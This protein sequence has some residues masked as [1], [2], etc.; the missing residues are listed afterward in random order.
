MSEL[1]IYDNRAHLDEDAFRELVMYVDEYGSEVDRTLEEALEEHNLAIQDTVNAIRNRTAN[2]EGREG[3]VY[4]DFSTFSDYLDEYEDYGE[5]L[6]VYGLPSFDGRG[7]QA[8][9]TEFVSIYS[10]TGYKEACIGFV[11]LLISTDIQ[12]Y[13]DFNPVNR[14]ALRSVCEDKLDTYNRIQHVQKEYGF[15]TATEYSSEMIDKYI[16]ILSSAHGTVNVG[17]EIET[18][19]Q[20]ESSSYFNGN[21]SLDDVIPVLQTRVQ[22]VLDETK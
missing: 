12:K 13:S 22:R 2:I 15:S 3:A 9:S 5:G 16:G 20:E 11:K 14:E 19:L 21:K 6:G 1:Y 8:V 17:R 4:G 10:D 7:P 18:I